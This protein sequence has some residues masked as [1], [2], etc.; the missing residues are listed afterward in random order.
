MSE[1]PPSLSPKQEQER[2]KVEY[3]RLAESLSQR[4]E[5][6]P[7]PG[8]D[9]AAYAVLKNEEKDEEI[10]AWANP[11]D[12]RVRKFQEQGFKVIAVNTFGDVRIMPAQSDD[13]FD[14][15]FPRHLQIVDGMDEELKKLIL[16]NKK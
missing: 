12:E 9:P 16:A 14:A 4:P 3:L 11:I 7:F 13:I 1:Q 5:A 15:V 8:I 10:A 6:L 2:R